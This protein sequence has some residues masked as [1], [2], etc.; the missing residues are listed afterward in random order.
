MSTEAS[1]AKKKVEICWFLGL[2]VIRVWKFW[3]E[4]LEVY[5]DF[6]NSWMMDDEWWWM[7]VAN[8]R[9]EKKCALRR[10]KE[11]HY[12]A[13]SRDF[14]R[15]KTATWSWQILGWEVVFCL[16][17]W[18]SE[19]SVICNI[20]FL[21]SETRDFIWKSGNESLE[22]WRYE[23]MMVRKFGSL[24]VKIW[25]FEGMKVWK[26]ESLEVWKFGSMKVWKFE[27]YV[28]GYMRIPDSGILTDRS[29]YE[30]LEEGSYETSSAFAPS[31]KKKQIKNKKTWGTVNSSSVN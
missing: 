13:R 28:I 12:Y 10:A 17:V 6:K 15:V 3:R 2:K 27:R 20:K 31:W 25:K 19:R 24:K 21:D 14:W 18:R 4:K 29:R 22:V 7:N 23:C 11:G 9:F 8:C 1:D 30:S 16:E 26:Y 5:G